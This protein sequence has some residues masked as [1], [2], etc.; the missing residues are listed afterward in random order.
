M[1]R[2]KI[3]R[4]NSLLMPEVA[5]PFVHRLKLSWADRVQLTLMSITVYPIRLL[6]IC[7]SLVFA[8][9]FARI[10]LL[11]RSAEDKKQP[12]SG[13]REWFRPAVVFCCRA[14]F[15][16][17]GFHWVKVKGKRVSAEEA[18]ILAI[19]PHSSFL[20]ALPVTFL[21]LTTVVAKAETEDV[22]LFGTLILFTQAVLV[23]REDPNSRQHTIQNIKDRAQSDGRWPQVV[24]FPEGTCTNRSC[25]ISFKPGAF[26]PGVPVQP[27]CIT[28]KNKMNTATWTWDG[29]GAFKV[30]W[31]TLCQFYS[32]FEIEFLPVYT[33]S[34]EE[35]EDAKLYGRNVRT[36]MAEALDVATTD[37][38]FEDCRLMA[39][40]ARLNMPAA[41]GLV[42]FCKISKKLGLKFDNAKELLEDFC[43]VAQHK[44]HITLEELA[45]HLALPVSEPLRE[46]FELYDRDGSG[47]IDFREYVIGFH[48]VARPANTEDTIQ[49][50]F[51]LFDRGGKGFITEEELTEIL[52][53]AFNMS[54]VDV[55]YL[56]AQVDIH[57]D[58]KI[59]FDEFKAYAEEKPEYAKLFMTYQ[60]L[61]QA[62]EQELQLQLQPQ[63]SSPKA[64]EE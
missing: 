2:P 54:H 44:D 34:E 25:L 17:G 10:A 1:A 45:N 55:E 57:C 35:K 33:P 61:Q 62:E 4:E 47:T 50:A 48:L 3:P 59:H 42:E 58:G 30:L 51:E 53:E 24:I 60:Q 41:T 63:P 28:Y 9:I 6:L 46:M 56:F 14:V 43:N 20:D 26:Y 37:H 64:K 21:D 31:L 39:Y 12:L 13:W 27:V 19:A 16:I 49:L 40:A 52:H 11:G 23:S 5:N 32:E 38:T 18:P 7:V 36:I 15:F 22:P 8:W 29:P